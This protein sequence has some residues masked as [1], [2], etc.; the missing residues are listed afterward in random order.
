MN[1][2]YIQTDKKVSW[3]RNRDKDKKETRKRSRERPREDLM[4][5]VVLHNSRVHVRSVYS[6]PDNIMFPLL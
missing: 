6:V 2:K 5:C 4:V 1:E 3:D